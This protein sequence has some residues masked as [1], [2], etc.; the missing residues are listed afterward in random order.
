LKKPFEFSWS[1]YLGIVQFFSLYTI[2]ISNTVV[3]GSNNGTYAAQINE[4]LTQQGIRMDKAA[5]EEKK[6]KA[7]TAENRKRPLSVSSE[8]TEAKRPKLEPD[9]AIANSA[10]FL[11]A[12]DFTSLPSALITELIVAN[13]E[14][15]TEPALIGLVQ[16]FRESRGLGT[17]TPA[18]PAPPVAL[19]I[20][21]KAIP[22]HVEKEKRNADRPP[23][24]Q[25]RQTTSV[26]TPAPPPPP[27][28]TKV[29]D[30]PLD[31]LQMD[32]DQD[33]LEYEP[34]R[35]NEEVRVHHLAIFLIVTD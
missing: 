8:Q 1:I 26:P 19:V 13:L 12:F 20:T 21:Q 6:R 24:P 3:R 5:S 29:K 22:P 2:N 11:A 35:L 17:P 14:A 18:A 28:V 30:E 34:D 23:T 31:P 10:S 25:A 15:F 33:E 4:A 27:P 9:P 7:A 16:A 32:I